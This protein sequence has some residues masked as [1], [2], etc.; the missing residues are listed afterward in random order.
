MEIDYQ[1]GSLSDLITGST[2]SNK[3]KVI[4]QKLELPV[5]NDDKT[6]AKKSKKSKHIKDKSVTK[7][8]SKKNVITLDSK[9][10]TE[11]SETS[12]CSED[13]TSKIK[14]SRAEKRDK[15]KKIKALENE[16][17]QRENSEESLRTIF[18]GNVPLS[19]NKTRFKRFFMKYG[20]VESVRFR[21]PPIKNMKI[22]TKVSIIKKEFDPDRKSWVSYVKFETEADAKNAL[23]ANGEIFKDHHIRVSLCKSDEKRDESRAIFIGNLPHKAE[24]DE[25]WKAFDCCGKIE[26]VRIVRDKHTGLGKG[27]AFVNFLNSDSVQL[28]LELENVKINNKELRIQ[29]CNAKA[30]RKSKNNGVLKAFKP[31][32]VK[33][34]NEPHKECE[35]KEQGKKRSAEE[36]ENLEVKKPKILESESQKGGKTKAS[37]KIKQNDSTE[38][39]FEKSISNLS[40]NSFEGKKVDIKK[41]KKKNLGLL[42]KKRM[43]KKIA[44][45]SS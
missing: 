38:Q 3:I 4:E 5:Q 32:K 30:A 19:A 29:A 2:S 44:P 39:S 14:F 22:P 23:K 34:I 20:K 7:K 1:I 24:D 43:S 11:V 26:S 12:K 45:K 33:K 6:I 9:V 28:A 31:R 15:V 10:D 18:V 17:L 35:R 16:K 42:K 40:T 25:L 27:F 8:T 36:D 37:R 21:C 13:A 41:K